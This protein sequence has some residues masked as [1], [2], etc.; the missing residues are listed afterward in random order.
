MDYFKKYG[1]NPLVSRSYAHDYWVDIDVAGELKKILTSD[2]QT[3]KRTGQVVFFTDMEPEDFLLMEEKARNILKASVDLYRG[4]DL[5]REC[6]EEMQNLWKDVATPPVYPEREIAYLKEQ[7]DCSDDEIAAF[8]WAEIKYVDSCLHSIPE[9]PEDEIPDLE[10][11]KDT[12]L[13]LIWYVAYYVL[14]EDD[15]DSL[16]IRFDEK[17]KT[18][19]YVLNK[20]YVIAHLKE[21]TR[22]NTDVMMTLLEAQQE[23]LYREDPE[24]W[25]R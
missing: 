21:Y 22:L 24:Y 25:I 8:V 11:K 20:G 5:E 12:G 7:S 6:R 2:F 15:Q 1:E 13:N 17:D 19:K 9:A 16:L 4:T 10:K 3:V 18:S 14:G 23:L